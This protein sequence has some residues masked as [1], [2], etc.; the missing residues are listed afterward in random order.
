MFVPIAKPTHRHSGRRRQRH[1]I[2]HRPQLPDHPGMVRG[3]LVPHLGCHTVPVPAAPLTRR[4]TKQVLYWGSAC[5]RGT[6]E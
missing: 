1:A 2:R 3:D 4:L 5:K 6:F